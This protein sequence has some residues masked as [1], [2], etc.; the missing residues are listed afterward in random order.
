MLAQ[1]GVEDAVAKD[2]ALY[3]G[4]N[5]YGGY[6]SYQPVAIDLEME[7]RPFAI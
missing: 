5:T 6:V 1:M 3:K 2:P 4:L 7:Y